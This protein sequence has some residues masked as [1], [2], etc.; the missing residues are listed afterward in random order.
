MYRFSKSSQHV[1]ALAVER[2]GE[3]GQR[4]TRVGLWNANNAKGRGEE[5]YYLLKA[6]RLAFRRIS[7][8]SALSIC[9]N[10]CS[11]NGLEGGA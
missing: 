7:H 11:G 10:K 6:G 9:I 1:L 3:R 5:G 2:E 8:C 4:V